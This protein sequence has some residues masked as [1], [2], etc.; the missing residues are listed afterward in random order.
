[1]NWQISFTGSTGGST[2][3]HEIGALKV[4]AQTMPTATCRSSC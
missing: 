4:C 3:I 1:V 2:N